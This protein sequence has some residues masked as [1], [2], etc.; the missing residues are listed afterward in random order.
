MSPRRTG[1]RQTREAL[2]PQAPAQ[3][4]AFRHLPT[5]KPSKPGSAGK[6]EHP[7]RPLPASRGAEGVSGCRA[8]SSWVGLP[9]P[10]ALAA[11]PETRHTP[12]SHEA[13]A[14]LWCFPGLFRC[15]CT[16]VTQGSHFD[17]KHIPTTLGR[18][19]CPAQR[20]PQSHE[21]AGPAVTSGSMQR[22]RGRGAA[23]SG[24]EWNVTKVTVWP[25]L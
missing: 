9:S 15:T 11:A 17:R 12:G 1:P 5:P 10:G 22:S 23:N 7:G 2:G 18:K 19:N 6:P 24:T 21:P 20:S 25:P 14:S 8:L 16:L 3:C 4:P 13:G